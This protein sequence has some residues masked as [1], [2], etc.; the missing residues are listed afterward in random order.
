MDNFINYPDCQFLAGSYCGVP[1]IDKSRKLCSFSAEKVDDICKFG[2]EIKEWI[3]SSKT[4]IT[5]E[6]LDDTDGRDKTGFDEYLF[7][8]LRSTEGDTHCKVQE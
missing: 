6:D 4:L 2:I 5:E 8:E 7:S 3:D 1:S